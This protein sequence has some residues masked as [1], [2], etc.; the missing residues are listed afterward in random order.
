MRIRK[1]ITESLVAI[2]EWS[3]PAYDLHLHHVTLATSAVP[4]QI[5]YRSGRT[6]KLEI[7]N[8]DENN[9]TLFKVLN[10][11]IVF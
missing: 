5:E 3:S 8:T 6:F 10:V 7:I 1:E 11:N 2:E 4:R 9:I